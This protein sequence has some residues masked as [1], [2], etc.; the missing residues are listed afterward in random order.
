MDLGGGGFRAHG[1]GSLQAAQAGKPVSNSGQ[2]DLAEVVMGW[3]SVEHKVRE[4]GGRPGVPDWQ[5]PGVSDVRGQG[6]GNLG[7]VSM[8]GADQLLSVWLQVLEKVE[9]REGS[10]ESRREN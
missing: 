2:T 7:G 1:R 8:L 9:E 6:G 4:R 3:G 5:A 10:V